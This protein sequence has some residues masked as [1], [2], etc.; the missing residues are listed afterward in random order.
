MAEDYLTLTTF[1]PGT[2]AK[3]QEVN[4]NFS[5]LKTA[6]EAKA[7][8]GGSSTQN[9]LVANATSD[10]HAINKAQLENLSNNLINEIEKAYP[11]FCIRSGNTTN[12]AA[13][14]FSYTGLSI[15]PKIGG[16]YSNLV[17]SDYKGV[18][19]TISAVNSLSL[20]GYVD[21]TYNI[22]I[23]ADS[24]LSAAKNTVFKQKTRPTM[25][26]GDI[27]LNT[28]KEPIQCIE[29]QSTGDVE[30]LG[31]PI[32]QVAIANSAISSITSFEFNRNGYNAANDK[33]NI[34][35]D[36]FNNT[37]KENLASYL[38]PDLDNGIS[39]TANTSY[40]AERTGWIFC[41]GA[42][43]SDNRLKINDKTVW[44]YHVTNADADGNGV[45]TIVAK[46]SSYTATGNITSFIFYPMKNA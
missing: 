17:I 18:K 3:A 37:G 26:V 32:G 40:T 41:Q 36:N 11:R 31:V 9:F 10:Y 4:A 2:K 8:K 35:A 42:S 39:K 24:T 27:W 29:C 22:F 7:A 14:L 16:T 5:A 21:G 12:G 44:R 6:V 38:T 13:D 1:E 15:T 23:K 28:S 34:E 19:T 45:M 46:G 30:F 43:W 33:A 20:T 25:T